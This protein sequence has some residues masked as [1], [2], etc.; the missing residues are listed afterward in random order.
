MIS[1]SV[2]LFWHTSQP[3]LPCPILIMPSAW[4][5]NDKYQFLSNWSNSTHVRS[6]EV[7][8]PWSPKM[9]DRRST[10]STTLSGSSQCESKGSRDYGYFCVNWSLG[11][12]W[13]YDLGCSVKTTAYRCVYIHDTVTSLTVRFCLAHYKASFNMRSRMHG[14]DCL[15]FGTALIGFW[16]FTSSQH[17]KPCPHGVKKPPINQLHFG[18]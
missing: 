11:K 17:Q 4:V 5:G 7:W 13:N 14:D 3:V 2:T 6:H 1:Q 18:G 12:D 8:I 15:K 10:H 9:G 16:S